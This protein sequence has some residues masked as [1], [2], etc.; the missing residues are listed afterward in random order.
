MCVCICIYVC[1]Y[2]YIYTEANPP[3]RPP[4]GASSTLVTAALP[5]LRSL[6]TLSA[7]QKRPVYI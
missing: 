2:I 4:P 6:R 3:M 1:I 7:P 5:M